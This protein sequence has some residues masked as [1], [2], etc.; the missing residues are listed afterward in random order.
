[1]FP[2]V[3]CGPSKV[4]RPAMEAMRFPC[5]MH[6]PLGLPV[7]PEVYMMHASWSEVGRR[8]SMVAFGSALPRSR[9]SS[10]LKIFNESGRILLSLAS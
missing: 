3:R 5:V 4:L 7:L 1:M 6:T 2:G 10:M 8:P 9:S